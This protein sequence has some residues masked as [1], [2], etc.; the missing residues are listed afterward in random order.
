[1]GYISGDYACEKLAVLYHATDG[2]S[3]DC[4]LRDGFRRGADGLAGSAIYFTSSAKKARKK[5]QGGN[6]VVLRAYVDLGF[7]YNVD[8]D[9]LA[10]GYKKRWWHGVESVHIPC[11]DV[12]AI[13]DKGRVKSVEVVFGSIY[14]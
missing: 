12:T 8:G 11:R 2:Y 7:I 13:R 10:A 4:I 6:S 9:E 3:A 1:M 5:S 14:A